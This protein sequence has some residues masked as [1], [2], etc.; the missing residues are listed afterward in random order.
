MR[1]HRLPAIRRYLRAVV[2]AGACIAPLSTPAHAQANWVGVQL[3]YDRFGHLANQGASCAATATANS[4]RFLENQYPTRYANDPLTGGDP[5]TARDRL[6]DGWTAPG[7][8]QRA[9]MGCGPAPRVWWNTKVTYVNDFAPGTTTFGGQF[10]GS[11]F[12]DALGTTDYGLNLFTPGGIVQDRPPTF[13]FLLQELRQGEDIEIAFQAAGGVDHAMTLTSLH[14]DDQNFNDV[15]DGNEAATLDYLDPNNP[16]QLFERPLRRV[17]KTVNGTD[18][19]FLEFDWANGGVNPQANNAF[20]YLAFTESPVPEP[21]TIVL[22]A[23]GLLLVVV[24]GRRA[25][26]GRAV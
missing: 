24:L 12:N 11:F 26:G 5:A 7:G 4:F 14:F 22:V 20:I 23:T 16:T 21:A 3:N 6:R 13:E 18:Y 15:W 9:G 2:V 8:A 1:L 17:T 10:A 25:R 19:A